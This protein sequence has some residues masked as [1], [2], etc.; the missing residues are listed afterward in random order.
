MPCRSILSASERAGLGALPGCEDELRLLYTFSESDIALIRLRRGDANR[1]GFAVQLALLHYPGYA[2][3][4]DAQVPVA[5]INW[6]AWQVRVDAGSWAKYGVRDETRREH[7]KEL[8]CYLGL[9]SFGLSDF[10]FLVR[11][12]AE[13]AMRTDNP[14]RLA[15]HAMAVLRQR[16]VILPAL[17]VIDRVC[18]DALACANRRTHR[19][20]VKPLSERHRCQLDGLLQVKPHGSLTWLTWLRRSPSKQNPQ[21]ILEHIAR[22]KTLQSLELPDGIGRRIDQNRLQKIAHESVKMSAADMVKL[23]SER[24]YAML[25]AE[26]SERMATV[27]DEIIDLHDGILL[28]LFCGAKT[29]YLQHVGVPGKTSNGIGVRYFRMGQALPESRQAGS[30]SY[31]A[32]EAIATWDDVE[33]G[34][35]DQLAPQESSGHLCF[36]REQFSTL[37]RYTPAFLDVFTLHATPAAQDLLDAI[38]VVRRMNTGY[39]LKVPADA[40]AGFIRLEWRGRVI[41]DAG[42]DRRLYEICTLDALKDALRSGDI[43]V[44]GSRRFK[45]LDE[46]LL[47]AKK[48]QALKRA[49]ELPLAVDAACDRYLHDRL[50]LLEERLDVVNR[51]ASTNALPG[52]SITAA[53]LEIAPL[54]PTK[55]AIRTFIEKATRRLPSVKL[56]ELLMDVDEWTDFTRHFVHLKDGKQAKDKTLLL[57]VILAD[58]INLGLNKMADSCPGTTYARLKWLQAWHVRETGYSAA[59]A[60]LSGVPYT[61]DGPRQDTELR[62]EE[63]CVDHAFA[64]AHLLGIQFVPGLFDM[65]AVRLYTVNN[66]DDTSA[67]KTLIGGV[68]DLKHIRTHWDE[69]LRLAISI[70]QGTLTASLALRKI[71]GRSRQ[72]GLGVALRELGRIEHTLFI[73]D[74]LQN[75]ELRGRVHAELERREARDALARSVF[76][77]RLD[78]V[79][80]HTFERDRYR[81]SGL[82]LVT[83]AIMFWNTV[84]LKRA[85]HTSLDGDNVVDDKLLHHL[86]PTSWEHIDLTGPYVWRQKNA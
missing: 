27:T 80:D 36:V 58:G 20:L 11:L 51:L 31:A 64:L 69:I 8:R 39:V 18:A 66:D 60:E 3:G 26:M 21:S 52:V 15:E 57:S 75:V 23:A 74:W 42:I 62:A 47:P 16:R 34:E 29:K 5:M 65:K 77:S 6:I 46:Y 9:S 54:E 79:R 4:T 35:S 2:L 73:L 41:S 30:V 19:A 70:R 32:I 37:R 40:P 7:V 45:S 63:H 10:R 38:K 24:R 25:L 50:T 55:D 1:L 67:L 49:N 44:D 48:F 81:A 22:L 14:L 76:V 72:D 28:E 82:N 84:H 13:V 61:H 71:G 43:W 17:K 56:T 68:L 83:Q 12:L 33:H 78:G 86:W 53:G 85:M 59:L